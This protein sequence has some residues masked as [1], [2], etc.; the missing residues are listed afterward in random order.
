MSVE[1]FTLRKHAA[2]LLGEDNLADRRNRLIYRRDEAICD[3]FE[4]V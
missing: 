2:T 3:W 4:L 1:E